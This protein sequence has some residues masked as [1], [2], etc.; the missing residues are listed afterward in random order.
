MLNLVEAS[1]RLQHGP[2]IG[3]RRDT[4]FRVVVGTTAAAMRQQVKLAL[5]VR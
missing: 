1:L 5:Q 4:L 3:Q 2:T